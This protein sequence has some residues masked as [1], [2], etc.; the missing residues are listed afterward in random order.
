MISALVRPFSLALLTGRADPPPRRS[1]F[2]RRP[3]NWGPIKHVD[4]VRIGYAL[5]AVLLLLT[6]VDDLLPMNMRARLSPGGARHLPDSYIYLT[7]LCYSLPVALCDR[8]PLAAWRVAIVMLPMSIS[9]MKALDAPG[10]EGL[11]YTPPMIAMYLLVLFHAARRSD[12]EVPFAIWLVSMAYMWI[13]N[14][15]VMGVS[16]VIFAAPLALGYNVRARASTSDKLARV[17]QDKKIA[18]AAQ[19]VLE[20]RARIARELHDV[21]AHHMSVIAIQAEAVPLKARGDAR[22]LEEGLAE[23][24]VMSVE[25]IAELRQVLGVLRD[26]EG[27]T[28]TA[29][30]PGLDRMEELV[31]HAQAAGLA[32]TLERSGEM[33]VPPAVGLSAYRIV[34]E[35]LS[36]VMRHAPGASVAVKIVRTPYDLRVRVANGP[37]TRVG[38]PSGA[39]HGLIGMRE[40]VALLGG[41]LETGPGVYG[42]KVAARLPL[43]DS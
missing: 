38:G 29:P 5:L 8:F 32:V 3:V 13:A 21:V 30:Q 10:G 24:R 41:T 6:T 23:I 39:G 9:V 35:S 12:R 40:R 16:A 2:L 14:D 31:A 1:A 37:G 26:Q 7:A 11:T 27:R 25:A 4:L 42:F 34:Q 19:A 36:N 15:S 33:D 28:E 17:A 20:E 22:Q 18:E 43:E